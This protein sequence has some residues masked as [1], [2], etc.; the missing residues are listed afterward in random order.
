MQLTPPARRRDVPADRLLAMAGRGLAAVLIVGAIGCD[1]SEQTVRI[2]AEDFRFTPVEVHVSAGRP[3]RLRIV[4]RGREPHEFKSPLLTQHTGP[5]GASS[6]LR[7]LPNQA[8]ETVVRTVPGVYL[9]SCGIR[10]HTGMSGM[11]IVE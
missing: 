4:N 6:S 8:A 1:S 7:V 11:I 3:I 9:F 2:V 10:G 5:T